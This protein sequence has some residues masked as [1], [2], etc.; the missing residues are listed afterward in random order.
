MT[1]IIFCG[2]VEQEDK[3]QLHSRFSYSPNTKTVEPK[4]ISVSLTRDEGDLSSLMHSH[5]GCELMFVVHDGGILHTAN[6]DFPFSS[7]NVFIV[8]PNVMHTEIPDRNQSLEYYVIVCEGVAFSANS[9]KDV[10]DDIEVTENVIM[11][12]ID[13]EK[14]WYFKMLFESIYRELQNKLLNDSLLAISYFN[15]LV[16]ELLRNHNLSSALNTQTN[17]SSLVSYAQDFINAYFSV[18]FKIPELASKLAVSYSTLCHKFKRET[19]MSPIEY[20]LNRQLTE[21][22]FMLINNDST[23]SHIC[24]STG[25][26]NTAYFSKLFR[27]KNGMTPKE[28]RSLHR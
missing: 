28:Y 9:E 16:T 25:F 7:G 23:I 8:N 22:E 1:N 13:H 20:R 14:R 15:I 3:N 17:F 12:K 11:I 10:F 21:A 26:E 19:G 2:I 4:L 6:K 5:Y 18:P 27:K 24:A